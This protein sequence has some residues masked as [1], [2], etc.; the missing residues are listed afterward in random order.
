LR[1]NIHILGA[2]PAGLALALRLLKRASLDCDISLIEKEP[3]TGGLCGS[4]SRSGI[5]F[6]YGSHRLH[7]CSDKGILDEIKSYLGDD[8]LLNKRNGRIYLSGRFVRFPLKPA[9]LLFH[10][11]PSF[12]AGIIRDTLLKPFR[13]KKG[14]VHSYGDALLYS[15]GKTMCERF[16]FPYAEKLWGLTPFKI[17]ADQAKRRVAGASIG[18]IMRK[19]CSKNDRKS[20]FYYP[21]NGFGQICGSFEK[22]ANELGGRIH[23]S[24]DVHSILHSEGHIQSIRFRSLDGKESSVEQNTDF[25]CSTI[26]VTS[27]VRLFQP[28]LP[29]SVLDAA[30]KIRF[31]SL[32]LVYLVLR[33]DQ[34]TPF[35]THY[36][37]EKN[38]IFSRISEP[39]NFSQC[40]DRKGLTGL[41]VEVP[42]SLG[43]SVCHA[44]EGEL[45]SMVLDDMKKAGLSVRCEIED[46]FIRILKDA[47]PLYELDTMRNFKVIDNHLSTFSNLLNFGRQG[48]LIHDNIHHAIEMANSAGDCI[49]DKCSLD[50][51]RWRSF[52][53]RFEEFVVED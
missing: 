15:L 34:F 38:L 17:S 21:K 8:L 20:V 32:A 47:Y 40:S 18:K 37:P 31:R 9:D 6:D 1:K 50:A 27:L 5:R 13:S 4:F 53:R 43:D 12:I 22:H 39:L 45:V 52:R 7:A 51:L 46:S 49:T 29:Q 35:D 30:D 3:F 16:Y 42:C 19:I 25:L 28:S 2:G 14:G 33:T 24:S 41:C 11:P 10:L 26:P 44:S 23:V 48:L 36:F